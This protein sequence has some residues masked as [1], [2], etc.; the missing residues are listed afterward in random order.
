MRE[1]TAPTGY[2]RY[3]VGSGR[4]SEIEVNS[5]CDEDRAWREP[6]LI[7]TYPNKDHWSSCGDWN[8]NQSIQVKLNHS[9]FIKGYSF[10]KRGSSPGV[11]M[12]SWEFQGSNNGENWVTLDKHTNDRSFSTTDVLR[13]K[14]KKGLFRYFRVLNKGKNN[15]DGLAENH[16]SRTILY[17][18]Y[19]DLYGTISINTFYYSRES[20]RFPF[21]LWILLNDRGS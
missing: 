3:L 16:L 17:I 1:F 20:F 10:E 15:Y 5:S 4:G 14:T 18:R 2:L 8:F 21:F 9:F 13:P 11:Y 6:R 12:M 19:L 7:V